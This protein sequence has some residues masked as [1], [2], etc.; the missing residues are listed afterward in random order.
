VDVNEIVSLNAVIEDYRYSP[1]FGKLQA[2]YP[3]VRFG[4]IWRRRS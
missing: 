4:G 3:K 2:D 1:E